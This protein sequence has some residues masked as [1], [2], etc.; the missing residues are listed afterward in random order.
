M[1][2]GKIFEDGVGVGG[3]NNAL[4]V[5]KVFDQMAAARAVELGKNLINSS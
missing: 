3:S 5:F 1:L 4:V 2:F